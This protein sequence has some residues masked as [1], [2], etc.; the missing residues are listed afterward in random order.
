MTDEER[1]LLVKD[2]CARLP[3]KVMCKVEGIEEPKKLIRI[4]VDKVDGVLLDFEGK[5]NGLP[6][7]VYLSEV[8]PILRKHESLTDKE[9]EE[10]RNLFK[11]KADIDVKNVGLCIW[12]QG[13]LSYKAMSVVIDK[14]VSCGI[15]VHNLI[16][17]GLAVEKGM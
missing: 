17:R 15:D 2:L 7:Q 12:E 9:K 6:P 1:N 3:Y 10:I 14:L 13:L 16:G 11:S 5:V 8:K 4:T